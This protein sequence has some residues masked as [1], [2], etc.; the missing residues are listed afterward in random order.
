M[1]KKKVTKCLGMKNR[2]Q[3]EEKIYNFGPGFGNSPAP[4]R[5]P[6]YQGTDLPGFD[7]FVRQH[8]SLDS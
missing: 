2:K 7:E 5:L 4:T 3:I 8:T 6:T 1:E